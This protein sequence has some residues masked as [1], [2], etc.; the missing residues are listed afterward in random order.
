MHGLLLLDKP[1]GLTSHDLVHKLRGLVR[2]LSGERKPSVGHTG[3]LDPFATG[4]LPICLG[5]ATRLSRFLLDADK[6]YLATLRLGQATDTE[7]CDGAILAERPTDHL[8]EAD[9]AAA[10]DAMRGP[11]QQLPPA[12]SAIHVDGRRAYELARAGHEVHLDPRPIHIHEIALV[13]LRL[14]DVVFRVTAS[15][16][17]Y[18]RSLCR[19][20]GERL[21]VGGHCAALRREATGGFDL[22]GAHTLDALQA[23][24]TADAL[25]AHLIAPLAM[26]AHLPEHATT[27]PEAASLRQ[28]RAISAPSHA[29][30]GDT[31]R[32]SHDGALV[33]VARVDPGPTFQPERVLPPP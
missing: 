9:V 3:T 30:P 17:T 31:W 29:Q 25:R 26:L 33:C 12:Y 1:P 15:K 4:L 7:D 21:G 2:R 32:L 23:L 27:A 24:T 28:G 20:L 8:T 14:P 16:G 11:Q 5:H 6:R 19:D 18:V 22:S 10:L 13:E